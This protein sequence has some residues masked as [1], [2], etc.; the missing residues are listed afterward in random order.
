MILKV[1]LLACVGFV[2]GV[3][4]GLLG[5]GGGTVI[6][7]TLRLG[8]GFEPVMATATSLFT[9]LFTS[10]SGTA[11]HLR[12]KTCVPSL[13]VALGLGGACTSALG[14]W[15]GNISPGWA[16]MLAAALVVAYGAIS[17]L[18]KAF[19]K[20]DADKAEQGGGG[21]S[22]NAKTLAIGVCIGAVA[23]V[24]SGYVGVGGGFIMVP[25]MMGILGMP[26]KK[27]SGTS[28][29]AIMILSIPGIIENGFLGNIDYLMG[30]CLVVG[31]I[32]GA[33]VGARLIKRVP[34]RQLRI[35]FAAFLIIASVLLVVRELV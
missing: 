7:P 3:L 26:M 34:E 8:F 33:I 25:M 30:I 17:M 23:G 27:T 9:I 18:R 19:A 16:V 29:I 32:P 5:I 12:N 20:V 21:F 31:S 28:L 6:V 14:V 35:L 10:V 2:I 24:A 22:P 15:L 1:I 11:T 4:S 13:G